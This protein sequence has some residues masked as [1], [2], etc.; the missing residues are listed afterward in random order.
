MKDVTPRYA[1]LYLE[2]W[3][4]RSCSYCSARLV[5]VNRLLKPEEWIRAFEVLKDVGVKFFL[6]LGNEVLVYPWIV[7]LVRMLR[8]NGFWGMYALYSTFPEPWYSMLRHR[9]VEAGLYNISAGVDVLP[10]ALTGDSSIDEKSIWGLEQL[11][12]FKEHG[13]PDVEA[14][15]TIHRFNYR[16]LEALLDV[17][18][19]KGIWGNVNMVHYSQDGK[20]DF[21]GTRRGLEGFLIPES[22][23]AEFRS[24]M[25]RLAS[26]VRS[27][28]WMFFPPP[29]YLELLGDLGGEPSWHCSLP[30]FVSIE[31]D[32]ELRLCGY[33]PFFKHRGYSI[34]DIG[35]RISIEDYVKWFSEE[36]AECPGCVWGCPYTAE[37]WFRRDV[38]FGDRVFQSHASRYWGDGK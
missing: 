7:D 38:D 9:L 5:K 35:K 37:Y 11:V 36:Q 16:H 30:L 18:T 2:R 24:V 17:V 29:E 20:H 33:R 14:T 12:W 1:V 23:R 21:Y 6:V 8:E 19:S 25:Y 10:N 4:P 15:I 26:Q 34:F 32:G 22:E 13:V 27:G 31:A 3:C 28:R